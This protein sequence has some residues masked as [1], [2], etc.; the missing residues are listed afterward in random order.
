M[1][2]K[3]AISYGDFSMVLK[4]EMIKH[5]TTVFENNTASFSVSHKL[6]AG[7]PVPAGYRAPWDSRGDLAA[8]ELVSKINASTTDADFAEILLSPGTTSSADIIEVHIYGGIQ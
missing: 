1:D 5:R 8:S 7:G 2:G 4:T 6:P 3:G